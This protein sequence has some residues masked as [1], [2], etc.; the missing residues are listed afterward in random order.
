MSQKTYNNFTGLIFLMVLIMHLLRV[1]KGWDVAIGD[2]SVPVWASWVGIVVAAT[3][4]Y[5]GL[6]KR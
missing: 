2:Y 4:S 3:L 6:R 5:H 1:L